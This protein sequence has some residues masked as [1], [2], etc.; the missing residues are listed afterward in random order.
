MEYINKETGVVLRPRNKGVAEQFEKSDPF[1]IKG[2][3]P[4]AL[5]P[6]KLPGDTADQM[7]PVDPT[8]LKKAELLEM[9]AD[10]GLDVPDGATKEVLI[11]AIKAAAE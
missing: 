9:A 1:A 3:T 8:K 6:D 11:E 10:A 5:P 4:S 7:A 2:G